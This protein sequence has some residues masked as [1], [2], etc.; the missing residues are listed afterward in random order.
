[1]EADRSRQAAEEADRQK[2]EAIRQKE[3]MRARLLAQLN[4]VLQTRDTPR[5][6]I[7]SMPDVLFDFNK[8]ALKPEARERLA[9]IS[10]IVLA[11]PDLH[12]AIEGYTDS[13]GTDEYNMSLS[14]KRALTVQSYLVGSGVAPGSHRRSRIR[15]SESGCRQRDRV[16]PKAE[17]PRRN[18][19]IRRRDRHAD[20]AE[21]R[22]NYI[23][24]HKSV[25]AVFPKQKAAD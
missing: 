1:M 10:G 24:A 20:H 8:F 7:V 11:Y 4:Q 25:R 23:H 21:R 6:L 3:A 18:G 13:I 19:R 5:G 15:Q 16:G 17:S 14:E 9:R 22:G 12:L 2:Q